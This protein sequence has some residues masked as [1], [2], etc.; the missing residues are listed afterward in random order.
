MVLVDTAQII[1]AVVMLPSANP[2]Q[3]VTIRDSIGYLSTPN[4]ITVSTVAG[5]AFADGTS[6]ITIFDAFGYLAVTSRDTTSWNLVNSYGFP[7]NRS[8]ASVNSLSTSWV[9]AGNVYTQTLSTGN[10]TANQGLFNTI[11]CNG[12]ALFSTLVI[13]APYTPLP[14]IDLTV[15]GSMDVSQNIT[16][17]GALTVRGPLTAGSVSTGAIQG[18][19]LTLQNGLTMSGNISAPNAFMTAST[20]TA[21]TANV[22]QV[23]ASSITGGYLSTGLATTGQLTT[24]S[25]TIN[26]SL[27]MQG[28]TITPVQSTLVFSGPITMPYFKADYV[29]VTDTV[30]TSNLYVDRSIIAPNLSLLQLS[31]TQITNPTGSL[32]I[33]SINGNTLIG[34]IISTNII[35]AQN[36]AASN[37]M[38]SGN[39]IQSAAGYITADTVLMNSLSTQR[40]YGGSIL[41]N[42][43]AV[44]SI[45]VESLDITGNFSGSTLTSLYV[46]NAELTASTITASTIASATIH[47]SSLTLESGV[48]QSASSLYITASTV[49]MAS[50][51]TNA[52]QTGTLTTSSITATQLVLGAPIDSTLRGPYFVC[53][54]ST[55]CVITGGPGDYYIPLFLSNVKPANYVPG[56]QY[57]VSAT[58]QYIIPTTSGN[59]P[60]NDVYAQNSLFWGNEV[61]TTSFVSIDETYTPISMYGYYA[62]DQ[63]SNAS[64]IYQNT[65]LS[66]SAFRWTA[67]MIN[68]SATTLIL[69][70]TS[71]ANYSLVDPSV[72]INMQNGVLKWDYALNAT[73]IQ[74]SLNDISTRN[75][76]YY[77]S[78]KFISDPNLKKDIQPAN[79]RRCYDIIRDI[80]LHRY[81]FI[82]S[83]TS[84]FQVTD[85]RRLGIMAD[86]YEQV[87]PKSVTTVKSPVPGLSTIKTVDT[88]Q[89]D[90]AHL[91]A[92]QYLLKEIAELRE[93][94]ENLKKRGPI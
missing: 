28:V 52:F 94:I 83:Y 25:L 11:K 60:G 90:M 5:V 10:V 93:Q 27:Q 44:N 82:D 75:L 66:P 36:L 77:G 19:S 8:V 54:G 1:N 72:Y 58:F 37:I 20:I 51:S 50:I 31:S 64:I 48:I 17:G 16:I 22:T 24:G 34:N 47:T 55:N 56:T 79:L 21:A 46:P 92:T 18:T 65:S 63:T 30:I 91:G 86:E 84:T 42:T 15:Y 33:S 38:V 81:E 41:A 7:Q 76:L 2:G 87:F 80:P 85:R 9:T 6:S 61:D 13:G 26:D 67:T 53:T 35:E 4:K 43:F 40:L 68:D 32:V 45:S 59:L 89:L 12:K 74:N 49:S 71:N 62:E 39:I 78:L 14:G 29:T 57:T 70:T 73:T 23:I 3:T 69:K 88:Q